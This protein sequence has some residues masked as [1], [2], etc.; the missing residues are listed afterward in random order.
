M[1]A[2]KPGNKMTYVGDDENGYSHYKVELNDRLVLTAK[3]SK[4]E[5]GNPIYVQGAFP[6]LDGS[7]TKTVL[8]AFVQDENNIG[9]E[10][11][12]SDS[13]KYAVLGNLCYVLAD[14]YVPKN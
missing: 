6:G 11:I 8:R 4:T 1:I 5:P 9:V 3:A 14:I 7:W 12:T 2:E 10:H 13:M